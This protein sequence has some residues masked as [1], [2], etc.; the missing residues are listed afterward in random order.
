[1]CWHKWSKWG[2]PFLVNEKGVFAQ[3]KYCLKCE[4]R[5]LGECGLSGWHL[6]NGIPP[7]KPAPKNVSKVNFKVA[8]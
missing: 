3:Q 1:M 5:K 7:A 4:K 2:E 6:K 8:K